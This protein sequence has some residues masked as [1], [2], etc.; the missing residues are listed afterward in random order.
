M[1]L[2]IFLYWVVPVP[3]LELFWAEPVKKTPSTMEDNF[4]F[5]NIP[6]CAL[7]SVTFGTDIEGGVTASIYSLLL[8]LVIVVKIRIASHL[9]ICVKLRSPAGG[10]CL[11]IMKWLLCS[12]LCT[13][14]PQ[15]GLCLLYFFTCSAHAVC[16]HYMVQSH[17]D[18]TTSP[19]PAYCCLTTVAT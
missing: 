17:L 15:F 14:Q 11:V 4:F 3:Y 12:N 1:N 8:H 13:M 18:N 2:V 19:P 5:D 6:F 9:I 7:G 10:R 16:K